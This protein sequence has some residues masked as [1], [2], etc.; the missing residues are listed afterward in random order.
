MNTLSGTSLRETDILAV[1]SQGTPKSHAT[2]QTFTEKMYWE[3]H[4]R[5]SGCFCLEEK[6]QS[7]EL[8]TGFELYDM[9]FIQ[10]FLEGRQ[11]FP[12]WGWWDSVA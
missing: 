11:S 10:G 6:Q 7:T 5:V 8:Y 2:Q 12:G 3:R 4:K 1:G 9:G